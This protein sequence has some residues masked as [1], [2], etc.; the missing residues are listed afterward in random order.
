MLES[1]E[2]GAE[3]GSSLLRE[4]AHE[5]RDALSPLASSADLAR[6]RNFD[7]EASRQ[8][9]E[10]VERS[11]SRAL[12]ILDA[13]SLAEQC[14]NG[15]LQLATSR[16]ALGQLVASA[17]EALGGPGTAARYRFVSGE[18]AAVVLADPGWSA[19]ALAAVLQ[20]AGALAARD[21]LVDVRIGGTATRPRVHVCGG[22]DPDNTPGEKWLVSWR[23]GEAG[24]SLRTARC[25]MKVQ[26]G[27]LELVTGKRGEWE[28]VIS[29]AGEAVQ[30]VEPTRAPAPSRRP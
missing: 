8:L 30:A 9:A 3:S 18:P 4:L 10:K 6:L 2:P 15:T 27:D 17:R 23:A 25:L 5:L 11:L 12:A 21:Q 22:I 26:R 1:A 29:F 24:M 14:E 7:A 28:L 20:H 16:V 19:R 13:F